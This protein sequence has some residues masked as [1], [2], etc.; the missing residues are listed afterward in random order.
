MKKCFVISAFIIA[1]LGFKNLTNA[2]APEDIKTAINKSLPL[3]QSSSHTFLENSGCQSCHGQAL[4]SVTFSLAKEKNFPVGDSMTSESNDTTYINWFERRYALTQYN[5][6]AAILVTGSYDLWGMSASGYKP[7]KILQLLAINIMNR[8]NANG[9]WVSPNA[10]PPLEYYSF[11]ATALAVRAIKNYTPAVLTN[12]VEKRIAKARQ[13]L[14]QTVPGTNEERAFQLLALT[15]AGSNN[16]H[17]I[18]QQAAKLLATQ[19]ADGG[20]AQLNSMKTD[21]YATG[22]ALYAL[23]QS[24]QLKTDAPAYQKGIS[25]LIGAQKEDG[26]WHIP[27]RSFASVPFVN[28][29][30]PHGDDQFI[31]AAGSNWATMALLLAIE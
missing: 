19:H 3:L 21:A 28:S 22:Q 29:G 25:F 5:D 16:Q 9:N 23:H 27:S 24:G 20:W 8:Q 30:F 1:I 26:S 14:E 2:P 7:N 17:F 13:W 6:P 10:R 11:S 4:G 18:K 31:S 12:E 15:W